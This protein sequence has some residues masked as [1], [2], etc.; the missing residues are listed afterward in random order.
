MFKWCRLKVALLATTSVLTAL[1]LSGC[2]GDNWWQ[3][4]K[5]YAIIDLLVD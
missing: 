2:L 5:Q 1:S 4:V 3:H